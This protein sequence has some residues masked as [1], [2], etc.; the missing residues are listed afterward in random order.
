MPSMRGDEARGKRLF[1]T[2]EKFPQENSGLSHAP[3]REGPNE[4]NRPAFKKTPAR[5][6]ESERWWDGKNPIKPRTTKRT[7]RTNK[8]RLLLKIRRTLYC[9][10]REKKT[11]FRVTLSSPRVKLGIGSQKRSK[12]V[13][14]DLALLTCFNRSILRLLTSFWGCRENT[15]GRHFSNALNEILDAIFK[16]GADFASLWMDSGKVFLVSIRRLP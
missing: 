1:R 2:R 13:R 7:L 9:R 3:R 6:D 10:S 14:V 16:K 15:D 8:A 11:I 4:K 5:W 12:E